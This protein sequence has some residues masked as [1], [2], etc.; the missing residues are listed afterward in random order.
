MLSNTH[1]PFNDID[2]FA[3]SAGP[4]SFT[5]IRI[6]ISAVKGMALPKNAPCIPVST[7]EAIAYN[8]L[9]EDALVC[10]V[11]DARCNQV[12]NALFRINK[13][14]VKRICEDR[15]VSIDFLKN[16]IL[17][18]KVRCKIIVAGDGA[19]LFFPSVKD[20]KNAVIAEEDRR[21]QN[22]EGVAKAAERLYKK[23]VFNT[24]QQLL[25]IYLRL[26][27]AERELK[28]KKEIKK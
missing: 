26:P 15:A 7:L 4:G 3:V 19:D 13:G 27:Q 22:G 8:F 25:P 5:G 21:L 18:S 2:A 20:K 6:G 17:K 14:K 9:N 11:M 23:G 16:E 24:A 12:Y 1:I 10:A 28:L